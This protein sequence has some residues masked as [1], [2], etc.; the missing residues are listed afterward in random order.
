MLKLSEEAKK[1]YAKYVGPDGKLIID[2]SLPEEVKES[3]QYFNDNNINILELN[4]DDNI[5]S[6]YDEEEEEL[7]DE[8][9]DYADEIIDENS[10]NFDN[11]TT[12]DTIVEDD[13]DVDI[14]GL[15]NLFG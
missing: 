5:T 14:D 10:E 11:V 8:S 4:V 7:L 2:D 15:N 1:K 9:D 12:N 6:E 13:S 3:F